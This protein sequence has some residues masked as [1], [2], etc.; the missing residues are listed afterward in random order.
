MNS[1]KVVDW[2]CGGLQSFENKQTA[3]DFI[4]FEKQLFATNVF[5]RRAEKN[6]WNLDVWCKE[7]ETCIKKILPQS[8]RL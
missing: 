1:A 5:D 6:I 4:P 7:K 2:D 3:E 8:N